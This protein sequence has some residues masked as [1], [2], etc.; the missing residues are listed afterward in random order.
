MVVKVRTCCQYVR[1]LDI[2]GQCEQSARDLLQRIQKKSQEVQQMK[3]QE[4]KQLE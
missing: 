4:Q 2:N 1:E 3:A